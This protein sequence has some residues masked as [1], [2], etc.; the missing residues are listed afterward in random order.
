[1]LK[2]KFEEEYKIGTVRINRG[3]ELTLPVTPVIESGV[4]KGAVKRECSI[5]GYALLCYELGNNKYSM[6]MPEPVI[7]YILSLA[8]K[9]ERK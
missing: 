5:K 2:V 8:A 3:A 4:L 9:E 7:D 6:Q 1:M